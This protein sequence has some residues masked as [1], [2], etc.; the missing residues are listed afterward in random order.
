MKKKTI[1]INKKKKTIFLCLESLKI[2]KFPIIFFYQ[3]FNN[4]NN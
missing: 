1:L 3:F 2:F 4:N